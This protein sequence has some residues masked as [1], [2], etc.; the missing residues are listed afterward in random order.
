M[1]HSGQMSALISKHYDL[2][3]PFATYHRPQYVVWQ[4]LRSLLAR[5]MMQP[6]QQCKC[7]QHDLNAQRIVPQIQAHCCHTQ[8]CRHSY[9]HVELAWSCL[10][11]RVDVMKCA[12]QN[13]RN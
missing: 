10:L 11:W 3:L 4:E 6:S 5:G 8:I 1:K 12:I 13:Y 7:F 9:S 2:G